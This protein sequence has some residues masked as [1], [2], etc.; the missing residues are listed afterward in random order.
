MV[1]ANVDLEVLIIDCID[2]P[3]LDSLQQLRKLKVFCSS[4]GEYRKVPAAGQSLKLMFTKRSHLALSTLRVSCSFPDELSDD[5]GV[6]WAKR[7]A[8]NSGVSERRV[9]ESSQ[10]DWFGGDRPGYY[11]DP[12][13]PEADCCL[14][15]AFGCSVTRDSFSLEVLVKYFYFVFYV[16]FWCFWSW[17]KCSGVGAVFVKISAITSLHPSLNLN[18]PLGK[19]CVHLVISEHDLFCPVRPR[20]CA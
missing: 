3:F 17:I 11:T 2:G 20:T 1:G 7:P 18:F 5:E 12:T 15:R 9:W 16:L 13:V 14:T 19:P 8:A 4:I 10:N 6:P